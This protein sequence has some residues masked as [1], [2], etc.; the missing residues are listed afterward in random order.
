MSATPFL[1]GARQPIT[2]VLLGLATAA[3]TVG[4]V[5]AAK[6]TSDVFNGT[7][8]TGSPTGLPVDVVGVTIL[9][10]GC[11]AFDPTT[12][13]ARA[14][15][16]YK[17]SGKAQGDVPGSFIYEEHGAFIQALAGPLAGQLVGSEFFSGVFTLDPHKKD[18]SNVVISNTSVVIGGGV[19]GK[20]NAFPKND[21]KLVAKLQLKP[22]QP[23]ATFTFPGPCGAQTGYATADFREIAIELPLSC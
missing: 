8:I 20:K 1:H 7:A 4:S 21:K 22:G 6:P 16:V 18:A 10:P 17:A 13:C 2:A 14:E 3:V 19:I 15:Y 12:P 9:P 5:L 23:Y 11:T